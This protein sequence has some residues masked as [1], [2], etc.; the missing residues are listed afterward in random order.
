MSHPIVTSVTIIAGNATAIAASQRILAAGPLTLNGSPG[1]LDAPRRIIITSSGND[2]GITFTI[3]GTARPEQNS[4]RLVETITGASGGAAQTTQDFATV[5][6][7]TASGATAG[8]VTVG[9]NGVASGPWVVWDRFPSNFQV[10]IQGNVLSGSPTF[11]VEITSDDVFGLWLP[12]G[13]PFPRAQTLTGYTAQTSAGVGQ[14][15]SPVV[16]SRLT[17]TV[18]GGAQITQLQQGN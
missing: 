17:L 4:A 8:T 2:T 13:V 5:T 3:T 6:S 9:T 15:T 10:Q 12:S 16:A 11:G 7:I 18:F 1:T 14:I